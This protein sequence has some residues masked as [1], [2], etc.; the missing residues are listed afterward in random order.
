MGR[1][2]SKARGGSLND[3]DHNHSRSIC[4]VPLLS[5]RQIRRKI[6][7]PAEITISHREGSI[8]HNS[9]TTVRLVVWLDV[10][11]VLLFAAMQAYWPV[12]LV[13]TVWRVSTPVFGSPVTGCPLNVQEKVAAG[14]EVEVQVTRSVP[15]TCT[16]PP[17]THC[18]GLSMDSAG[19]SGPSGKS[20]RRGNLLATKTCHSQLST[21]MKKRC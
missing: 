14:N 6:L 17:P 8:H 15:P 10:L 18:L 13:E 5:W 1:N 2:K 20:M 4:S 21:I 16:S 3:F 9:P 19:V 7:K 11:P 12:W